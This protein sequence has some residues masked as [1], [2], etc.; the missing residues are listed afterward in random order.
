VI[1]ERLY[2]S[3]VSDQSP[4]VLVGVSTCPLASDPKSMTI[5]QIVC[6]NSFTRAHFHATKVTKN[7]TNGCVIHIVCQPVGG[8]PLRIDLADSGDPL[9][10]GSSDLD[11]VS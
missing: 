7:S 11:S 1:R 2:I 4:A 6:S 8:R 3:P 10:E 9:L 5:D